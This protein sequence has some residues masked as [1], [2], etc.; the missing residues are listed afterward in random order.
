MSVATLGNDWLFGGEECQ[1]LI[2]WIKRFGAMY[3]RDD[4]GSRLMCTLDVS[5]EQALDGCSRHDLLCREGG[6]AHA[7]DGYLMAKRPAAI[8]RPGKVGGVTGNVPKRGAPYRNEDS[9]SR[10]TALVRAKVARPL[11]AIACLCSSI[12]GIRGQFRSRPQFF[13]FFAADDRSPVQ[14]ALTARDQ[15]CLKPGGPLH[16]VGGYPGMARSA[17]PALRRWGA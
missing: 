13:Y 4:V 11:R 9:A 7:N 17:G 8:G 14:R 10:M 5:S 6:S 16:R 2:H 1:G 15:V 12:R 3:L